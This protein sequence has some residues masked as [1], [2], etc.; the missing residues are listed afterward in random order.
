MDTL[1][2]WR[3][4]SYEELDAV[5]DKIEQNEALWQSLNIIE[6]GALEEIKAFHAA[7]N[8]EPPD[9]EDVPYHKIS[10]AMK[11]AAVPFEDLNQVQQEFLAYLLALENIESFELNFKEGIQVYLSRDPDRG[12]FCTFFFLLNRIEL[13]DG[14]YESFVPHSKLVCHVLPGEKKWVPFFKIVLTIY[15]WITSAHLSF[16]K[17]IDEW[18]AAIRTNDSGADK[19]EASGKS[20]AASHDDAEPSFSG[21]SPDEMSYIGQQ[22]GSYLPAGLIFTFGSLMCI[23]VYLSVRQ[24]DGSDGFV[25]LMTIIIMLLIGIIFLI[26]WHKTEG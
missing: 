18:R 3:P 19:T 15:P 21:P 14:G 6:Q 5:Y 2:D 24:T 10:E 12:L 9:A 26:I 13:V 8:R 4:T 20:A 1:F 7:L 17:S 25:F 16:Y 22:T 11:I 23:P